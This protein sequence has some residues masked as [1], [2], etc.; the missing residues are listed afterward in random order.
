MLEPLCSTLFQS[1]RNSSQCQPRMPLLFS[2]VGN[3]LRVACL[4]VLFDRELVS[5]QREWEK[6][7][8]GRA[9]DGGGLG[10]EEY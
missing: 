9:G 3:G 1:E 10:A 6:N 5:M 7:G 8:G 2:G 4:I